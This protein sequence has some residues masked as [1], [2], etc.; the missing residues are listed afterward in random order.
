MKRVQ[1]HESSSIGALFRE[2][3]RIDRT[4]VALIEGERRVS[5]GELN[6]RVNRL[7][8]VLVTRGVRPGDR[9]AILAR[10][11]AAY[12]ELELAAA[13]LG[14]LVAALNWRLSASE[15]SHC[16]A[17]AEPS[18]IVVAEAYADTI[19][20]VDI[21]N[22]PRIVLG[23][24]YDTYLAR[25]ENRE[26]SIQGRGEDGL[27]ILYTSGTTGRP[28]GAVISHRALIARG[29]VFGMDLG[30][31]SNETFVAWAPFFHMASTDQALATLMRGGS[32]AIIDGY[33]AHAFERTIESEHIG[34][35][36]LIP[37][38]IE[39]L[40]KDL[41]GRTLRIKGIRAIGAMADLV[42]MHHI[43]QATTVLNAPYVNSFGATE[44]G[45][46]PASAGLIPIGSD[47]IDLAKRQS[48]LCEIRLVDVNDEDVPMGMPGEC[49]I[50]GAT[51]F[52]GYWLEEEVNAQEF[53]G[54]WFHMGDVF[55]RHDDG[56]LSFM[57][58][59]KYLIKS[60]GENIY[61]A[62]IERVLLSDPGV[63]DA[64][65]VRRADAN[66]GEVP[67]AAVAVND[68]RVTIDQLLQR[69]E[70]QLAHYKLPKE[71]RFVPFDDLPRSATGKVQR[72]EVEP[73]F[74]VEAPQVN[75]LD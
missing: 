9:V 29:A 19:F 10:N 52:S 14:V 28:K 26:P 69:C 21:A 35:L 57:D 72:H 40:L 34:W 54:G 59:V 30:I 36:P 22:S 25:A 1:V 46:P 23:A 74:E 2:R 24:E 73:W 49:A 67:V 18:L 17:L 63:D 12:V 33:D 3:A 53:R 60:G 16:V 64:V 62:E 43:T 37:G 70:R 47:S 51:L 32:V 75:S 15:L 13:K 42:A 66:W 45:L 61:P 68:P 39:S 6:D 44:T 55:I 8:H 31:L 50:R 20:D 65:V 11:C 27:V 41:G 58:R 5:Y 48:S 71:I 4:A 56:R 38:M 7:V